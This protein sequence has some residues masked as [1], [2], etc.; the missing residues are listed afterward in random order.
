VCTVLDGGLIAED[1]VVEGK[2]RAWIL[3]PG[4]GGISCVGRNCRLYVMCK[5][6]ISGRMKMDVLLPYS[7]VLRLQSRIKETPSQPQTFRDVAAMQ[8]V[9]ARLVAKGL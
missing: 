7:L 9:D 8:R 1:D 6:G 2:R 5:E 4:A 3:A